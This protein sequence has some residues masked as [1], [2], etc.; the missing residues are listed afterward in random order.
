[1][2]ES[3]FSLLLMIEERMN[4]ERRSGYL[5]VL[6]QQNN[7]NRFSIGTMFRD[8]RGARQ[9]IFSRIVR[10][11][12]IQTKESWSEP[13]DLSNSVTMEFYYC[14]MGST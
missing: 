4:K 14:R 12:F 10:R 1:M 6:N 9:F 5:N 2:Q 3:E 7:P 8:R 13:Y 11:L